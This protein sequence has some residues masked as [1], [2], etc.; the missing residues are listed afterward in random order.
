M[1]IWLIYKCKLCDTTWN[2]TIYSRINPTSINNDLLDKFYT[3]NKEL[4]EKY[5]LDS[6]FL[7]RKGAEIGIPDYQ[8]HGEKFDLNLSLEL[9]ILSKY[10]LPIKLFSILRNHLNLSHKSFYNALETGQIHGNLGLNL[11]K[12]NLKKK[13]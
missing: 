13:I 12:C 5:A 11:K 8:V 6:E 7:I 2:L 9:C 4:V 3:N 10:T 1:D